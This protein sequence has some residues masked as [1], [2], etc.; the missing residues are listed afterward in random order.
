VEQAVLDVERAI[1]G[2]QR[3][4]EFAQEA[5]DPLVVNIAH[6]AL[7]SAYRLEGEIYFWLQNDAEAD[8][9][10]SLA[11]EQIIPVLTPLAEAGQYRI[12]A[13]AYLSLGA[14]YTQQA[15]ILRRQGDLAGGKALYEKA[16]AAYA[17]CIEQ[18]GNAPEDDILRSAI[19]AESCKPWD[20]FATEALLALE[21]EKQ[22]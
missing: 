15:E 11:I 9:F 14:A 4:L 1:D 21:G 16:R 17:G 12:L 5:R 22:E 19:I 20:K 18:E 6:L 8:H 2:Y 10:F 3:G 7:A 13:Q